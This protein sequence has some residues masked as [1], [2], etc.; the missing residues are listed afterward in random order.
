MGKGT[1]RKCGSSYN[2]RDNSGMC[3]LCQLRHYIN[4]VNKQEPSPHGN[5]LSR[6]QGINQGIR[7][8]EGSLE[9]W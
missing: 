1:C 4:T 9:S 2:V 6:L 8:Y 3:E 7:D 5:R